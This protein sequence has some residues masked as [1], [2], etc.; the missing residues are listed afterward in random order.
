MIVRMITALIGIP[1]ILAVLYYGKLPLLVFV[2]LV[3]F[4]G[5]HEYNSILIKM[6]TK[7]WSPISYLLVA[8]FPLSVYLNF[9]LEI[10]LILIF[11]SLLIISLLIFRQSIRDCA[12]QYFGI[13]YLGGMLSYILKLR[14]LPF[15][16]RYLLFV[17]L[18]IWMTDTAAY[19]VGKHFGKHK[20]APNISPNKTIEGSLG[21]VFFT[22]LLALFLAN[23]WNINII[24]I[25][26]ISVIVSVFAQAGDL[27][28]SALKRQANVKDSGNLLPGHG[29]V[30]DRFDSTIF[31]IPVAYQFFYFIL[32]R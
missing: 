31:A 22:G 8:I 11:L 4:L 28:E 29:G 10:S 30:L 5:M 6:N 20:L 18:C 14:A 23:V 25:V 15:G 1:I 21:G 26:S 2:L 9:N 7:S 19:F 12:L 13:I 24:E 17:F 3:V 16:F 27:V 32:S